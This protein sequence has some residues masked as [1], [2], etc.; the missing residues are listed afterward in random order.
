M[1]KLTTIFL[2]RI[3][4]NENIRIS[5]LNDEQSYIIGRSK[6][7]DCTISGNPMISRQHIE[8]TVKDG[9]IYIGD[10]GSKFLTYLDDEQVTEPVRVHDSQILKLAD[11]LFTIEFIDGDHNDTNKTELIRPTCPICHSPID[12]NDKFCTVCG[13]FI[14]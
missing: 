6:E 14:G 1:D 13:S 4:T 9:E 12:E 5:F 2:K 11:E 7:C 3:K 10:L 8:I